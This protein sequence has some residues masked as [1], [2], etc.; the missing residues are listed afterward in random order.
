MPLP[1]QIGDR[2]RQWDGQRFVRHVAAGAEYRPWRHAG[3]EHRETG[4]GDATSGLAGVRVARPDGQ[5]LADEFGT[6]GASELAMLVVLR[7]A[8]EF[9]PERGAAVGLVAD[10]SVTIPPD[11]RY[12][13]AAASRNC[14]L[15]DITLPA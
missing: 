9:E 14:Q 13:L 12:R 1:N 4:I 11:V 15:L 3:W 8:V 10:S 7:G 6:S 5:D 2:S